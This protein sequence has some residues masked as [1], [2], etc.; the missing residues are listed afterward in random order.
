LNNFFQAFSIKESKKS[1]AILL[2]AWLLFNLIQSVF[3][4]LIH[5]EAYYWVYSK[6]LDWGYFDHPPGIAVFIKLG[7][8]F[9]EGTL[10]VRILVA[11][12][13]TVSL[14]LMWKVTEGYTR[15]LKTF[16]LIAFSV[17][18]VHIGGFLAVPDTALIFFA[19]L[20]FYFYQKYLAQDT[21][22]YALVLGL[23]CAAMLYS[24]YHGI[25]IIFFTLISNL[26]LMQRKTFWFMAVLA[27]LLF[28]PHIFWQ[29]FNDFP[30]LKYHLSGRSKEEYNIEFTISYILGQLLITGPLIGI[31]L[32]WACFKQK[33][34]D[35]FLKGLKFCFWGILLFFFA[36]S[37]K[38]RVEANWTAV[39]FLPMISIAA[40]YSSQNLRFYKVVMKLVTPSIIILVLFRVFLM[41]D[42]IPAYFNFKTEVH[43]WDKWAK[44]IQQKA[45]G[46]PVVFMSSYQKASKYSFYTGEPSYSLN[47]VYYRSNQYNLWTEKEMQFQGKKVL[48]VPVFDASYATKLNTVPE[49]EFV[50]LFEPYFSYDFLRVETG[51][52]EVKL[53][54]G[55]E[56][57]LK[58]V[59]ENPSVYETNLWPD[60]NLKVYFN[61]TIE[62]NN[63]IVSSTKYEALDKKILKPG[64]KFGQEVKIIAPDTPGI[65]TMMITL[66]YNFFPAGLNG[67]YIKLTVE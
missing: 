14:W 36:S 23:I 48:F 42:F 61:C 66:Q 41:L 46:N 47:N 18:L 7:T 28:M 26:K 39:A 53:K 10:G 30:T 35:I 1:L 13:S 60:E 58:A 19:A 15:D 2:L 44:E 62:K 32:F 57:T 12:T 43:N 27:L 6:H 45:N 56:L 16:F 25:L 34:S 55:Q 63:K 20:F 67:N 29:Y 22:F 51:L 33:S 11:I 8:Y 3:T 52:N 64:E 59:V 5:D 21:F 17:I 50:V 31:F 54:P 24:K 37:F 40:I 4:G 38:G 65:Y 49:Q 9:F